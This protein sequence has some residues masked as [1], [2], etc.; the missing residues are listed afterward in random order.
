MIGS[1]CRFLH[2]S[3]SVT[4]AL[5]RPDLEAPAF[6][7]GRGGSNLRPVCSEAGASE[8]VDEIKKSITSLWHGFFGIT[9]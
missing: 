1:F 9:L 3:R 4:P 5:E 7:V 2:K 6:I 8:Q